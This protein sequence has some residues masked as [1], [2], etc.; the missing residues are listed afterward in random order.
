[1]ESFHRHI[2]S[3]GL[4]LLHF[5]DKNTQ[6]VTVNL[7]YDVGSKD[8]DPQHTGFAHLFEHL[9][10][11]GSAHVTNFDR[12]VEEA[13]GENNAWTSNDVT[14][15]YITLPAHNLETALYLES[16]RMLALNIHH[17]SLSTQQHVV[18]EEFKQRLLNQ[19][20]GDVSSL[21]RP[22]FYGQ[23]PYSW[24]TIGK[25]LE[26]IEQATLEEVRTFFNKHYCPNRCVM[27]I[28]GNVEF[29]AC[30]EMVEKWFGD[31]PMGPIEERRFPTIPPQHQAA[32]L[33][34]ERDVPVDA[35][36]KCW[37]APCCREEGYVACDLLTDILSGGRSSRLIQSLTKKQQIFA[38]LDCYV[39]SENERGAGS[40]QFCGRVFEGVSL[41][42][43]NDALEQE[44][45]RLLLEGVAEEEL[46]K[47]KNKYES[48][49]LFKHTNM[50][51][52]ATQLCWFELI[53]R[54]EDYFH[55]CT[56]ALQTTA[57]EIQS[58]AAQVFRPTNCSSL[59]YKA[60]K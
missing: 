3:N 49:F 19:P 16:D 12:I 31:I 24:P 54:A 5:R 36:Y 9:M 4:R 33:E 59:Y 7:M 23:H 53:G 17:D 32:F 56:N 11:A 6:M 43:A 40:I 48:A 50:A 35:L 25:C 52:L 27:A 57:A 1:M 34:V 10:F 37:H 20:Y 58:T 42:E 22:L 29:D 45:N 15:Y 46:V 38:S 30:V 60:K 39:G 41:D 28:C 51:H 13:L 47:V 8:E 18:V 14:N 44:I 21:M 55:Q 2:L 26:H